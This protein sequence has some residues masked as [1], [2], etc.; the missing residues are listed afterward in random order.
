MDALYR[1]YGRWVPTYL[2]NHPHS[3]VKN[4]L[5]KKDIA[6]NMDLSRVI[7]NKLLDVNSLPM[8][9]L[10]LVFRKHPVRSWSALSS[11][12]LNSPYLIFDADDY[13]VSH[14]KT[15]NNQPEGTSICK[16]ED[17]IT[18]D[19]SQSSKKVTSACSVVNVWEMV[20]TIQNLS[21]EFKENSEE[22][23]LIHNILAN[24]IETLNQ[25]RTRES[26]IPILPVHTKSPG[27]SK[28]HIPIHVRKSTKLPIDHVGSHKEKITATSKIFLMEKVTQQS[29]LR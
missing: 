10:F 27:P 23:V 5:I 1:R 6:E 20:T 21:F 16:T 13:E 7:M 8:Q 22:I 29:R 15:P 28:R 3:L 25:A 19:W 24:L 26:G 4:C 18:E 11:L 17:T 9:A 14:E 12:Y 2:Y